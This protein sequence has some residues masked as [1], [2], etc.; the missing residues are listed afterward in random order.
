MNGVPRVRLVSAALGVL[1]AVGTAEPAAL[2]LH[3]IH[4][5]AV[6]PA[7]PAVVYIATHAGLV[8]GVQDRE[9]QFVGD[10]R[11]DFMGFT[12]H[13]TVPGLM[14]ASGHPAEDSHG[15]NPRGVIVSRDGGRTWRPLALEGVAD[16]H[17]LTLSRT[18]GD[19]LYGWNVVRNPGLYRVSRRNG[20]WKR[21]EARGLTD[22]FSLAAHPTERDTLLAGTRF[23][24]LASRD[25]G[26]SWADLGSALRG[27]P[28]TAIAF[29]PEKPEA[30]M[31]YAV[32]PELGLIQSRDGGRTWASLGMFLGRE[33]A[34]S[35]I[36]FHRAPGRIYLATFGSDLYRST[37]GG[38]RWEHLFE[39]GRP[40]QSR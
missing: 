6:D 23:G 2:Q 12:G 37:D 34:V 36:A 3:H 1:L 4:G 35:H 10:D 26:Q 9:W 20:G 29:H 21:L 19:T 27:V 16:F 5:L 18:D 14:V 24:L 31:A 17:V 8:K 38:R 28:V 11:S 25:G 39:R 22:V 15:P 40:V 30:L 7:D 13:P 32:H 33:D